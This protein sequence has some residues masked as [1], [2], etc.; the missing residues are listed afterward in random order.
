MR[1]HLPMR[2][3][4][5]ACGSFAAVALLC[6][7]PGLFGNRIRTALGG[8]ASAPPGPLWMAAACF[9][10]SSL[11]AALA[12]RVALRACGTRL[13]VGATASR[14]LVGC[15]VNAMA[16]L[17]AGSALRLAL[18]ARLTDGGVWTVG[19]AVAA[20]GAIRSVW[21]V[22][23][24]AAGSAM[25]ALP[26]WPLVAFAGAALGLAAVALVARR[27]PWPRRVAH[28]LDAFRAL[29]RSPRELAAVAA[30]SL[31]GAAAKV[32]AA[33]AVAGAFGVAHALGAALVIVA[34]VELAAIMPLTPGNVGVASATIALALAAR[35][36]D[37]HVGLAVGI[38][39]GAVE[40]LTG[41]GLGIAGALALS[42]E[43]INPRLVL[44][45]S[46]AG[47]WALA[48]AFGATV[49][50]PAL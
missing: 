43:R 12:W 42:R 32:G 5:I 46:A 13:T 45:A 6:V 44:A 34:A 18:F 2:H 3:L 26:A 25:G 19:G 22:I 39:F 50:L 28:V 1:L 35:G 14:Y 48:V 23:L 31:A 47:V 24:I 27:L 29:V 20:V 21:L 11:C 7:A 4:V 30:W 15:G 17:H 49:L 36:I 40:W 10:V 9:A 37:S 41:L 38:A 33:A 16:P 8:V